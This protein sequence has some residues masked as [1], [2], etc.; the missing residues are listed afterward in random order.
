VTRGA[1]RAALAG[2]LLAG[3]WGARPSPSGAWA[4]PPPA[5]RARFGEL[6]ARAV[7]AYKAERFEQAIL[8]FEE[9]LGVEPSSPIY[10]NL[11]VLYDKRDDLERALKYVDAFLLDLGQPEEKRDK[12]FERRADLL[13]RLKAREEVQ[14]AARAAAARAQA[15][16][17]AAR[18]R[19]GGAPLAPEEAPPAW[20][21]GGAPAPSRAWVAWTTSGVALVAV[22]SGLHLYA[23]SVW[24]SR[25]AGGGAET[26][27]A[28]SKAVSTSWVADGLLALGASALGYGLISRLLAPSPA[29]LAPP[30][31]LA[32]APAPAPPSVRVAPSLGGLSLEGVF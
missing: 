22:A 10:W 11:A 13:R 29:P 4:E 19:L 15:A 24:Q 9:A 16:R 14:A 2:A 17:E 27:R 5:E 31:P 28:Q 23:D 12:A 21:A 7:Q 3:A 30:A 18:A 6:V 32:L 25:P 20:A 26:L 1:R 8:L